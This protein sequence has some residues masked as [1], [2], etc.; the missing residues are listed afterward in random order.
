MIKPNR[1]E[2]E[3]AAVWPGKC[4]PLKTGPWLTKP[5][6]EDDFVV[7]TSHGKA[8]FRM[9]D[10]FLDSGAVIETTS[11]IPQV[12]RNVEDALTI[13]KVRQLERR[14]VE[15]ERSSSEIKNVVFNG[16]VILPIGSLAPS[17]LVVV[18]TMYFHVREEGGVFLSS[19]VDANINASGESEM[20]AVDMLKKRIVKLFKYFSTNE[21]RLGTEPAR[22]LAVLREFVRRD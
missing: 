22:Q 20:D 17:D 6:T 15:V 1:I 16:G 21:S 19:F 10:V 11:W 13:L 5:W 3:I 12:R 18:K 8:P 2:N 9:T 7:F 4:P 14:L